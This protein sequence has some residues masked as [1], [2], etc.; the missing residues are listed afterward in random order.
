MGELSGRVAAITGGT[1]GIGR[2]I[3]EAFLRDGAS[4]VVNG[5]SGEKGEQALT[6]IRRDLDAGD[7]IHFFQG[8][9][10]NKESCEGLIDE[11]V[12]K[13][14]R[15]DILVNNAGGSHNNAPVAQLSDEAM[16]YALTVNLWST[17][18]CSRRALA[19]MI[20]Q[21]WGRIINVSSLE[22]KVGKPGIATYV[23]GKHAVNG[24]TKAM[25]HE[26]GPIGITVNALCPGAIETDMMKE[27]GT[28]AAESMGM[29]YEDL[30]N[31]F[32]QESAIKRLNDVEDVAMVASLL[33]SEAGA[34]ITGSL[35][36]I[37]GGSAPY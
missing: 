11:A 21:Q 20:P 33:A 17:F 9:A 13:Y 4:V 28:K 29:A 1:R 24:L 30:L 34:G 37:D 16:E 15:I 31:W 2:A 26:L 5:R 10:T 32:A 22:G 8:D 3:A 14:G 35:I 36:S 12:D 19:H 25:S 27:E 7:R 18:W 6:E 23:T